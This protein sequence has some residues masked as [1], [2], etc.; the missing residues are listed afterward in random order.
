MRWCLMDAVVFDGAVRKVVPA[1][2]TE[3]T[4]L[5][6]TSEGPYIRLDEGGGGDDERERHR[7]GTD[8]LKALTP[9]RGSNGADDHLKRS[10]YAWDER[11]RLGDVGRA[12]EALVAGIVAV[13]SGGAVGG[14]GC[15]GT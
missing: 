4:T 11:A 15:C 8:R 5:G 7:R 14:F 2:R 1:R 12:S 10:G 6:G 9:T 13:C 3:R